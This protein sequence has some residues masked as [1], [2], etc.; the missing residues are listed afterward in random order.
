MEY[1]AKVVK[2]SRNYET[3]S[4]LTTI[5][6]RLPWYITPEL[7]RH[8][9][10]SFSSRS[11]RAVPIKQMLREITNWPTFPPHLGKNKRG[12]QAGEEISEEMRQEIGRAHV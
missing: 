9:Q 2:D 12:M 1:F 10:F 8:R 3:K 6:V 5:H 11:T 7:L 4:R